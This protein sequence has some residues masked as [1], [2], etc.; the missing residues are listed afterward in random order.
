MDITDTGTDDII[1]GIPWLKEHNPT[2]NWVTGKLQFTRCKHRKQPPGNGIPSEDEEHDLFVMREGTPDLRLENNNMEWLM[3]TKEGKDPIPREYE[4]YKNLFKEDLPEEALPKHQPWDH[5]IPLIEGSK[6]A[7]KKIYPMNETQL[8]ALKEYL[9]ENLKKG[10]IR[11][12]Q[13]PAGYPLF[14]VPKKGGK[15]RPVI[16]YRQLNEIT[17]KNRYPLPL[18]GE[19]MDRLRGANWFTT[20]D[21]KGAYNLIR[22]KEG[23]EW[24]T[25]FRT[26]YGLYEYLVMPFG[27]TNAPASFQSFINNVLRG[28][29]DDFVVVYLDDILIYSENLEQHRKHVHK[30]L[31]QL[32]KADLRIEPEKS[33]FHKQEVDFLG[34]VISPNQIKMDPRKI[35]AI[36]EWPRPQNVKDIQS[37]LGFGNFY[38]RFIQGYSKIVNPLTKLTRKGV[39]F[40]WGTEQQRAFD[41]L[42]ERF[43]KAPVLTT[44][45]PNKQITLETDASDYAIGACLSQPDQNNKLHPVAYYSRTMSPAE[46]NYDIHDKELLAIVVA[47]E[48]WKVYLEGPQYPVQV[49]TDHK[50]LTFFTST[51]VLNRR[52][53]RWAEELA[54]FNY[55]ISYQKGSENNR[56]DA[57][58][59][60]SDYIANKKPISHAIFT[61]QDNGDI[62]HNTQRLAATLQEQDVYWKNEILE[63][64][65]T[66]PFAQT[67]Q[68]TGPAGFVLENNG[69]WT[70]E[71]RIYVPTK[72]HEKVI[73]EIHDQDH[74]GIG[75]TMERIMRH[76]YVPQLRKKV[77][78]HIL[79]CHKCQTNKNERHKPYGMLQPI[80][81]PKGAWECLT[82][83][84]ITDLPKSKG[85][86]ANTIHDTIVVIVDKLT[87]YA[88]FLPFEKTGTA[89]QLA[90]LMVDRIFA[91]H[92]MPSKLITD[93][94]KLFL[95]QFWQTSMEMMGVKHK[96]STAYHPQTDGQTERVNQT[97]EQYLRMFL[98]HQQDNWA[99]ILPVAQ[100]TYNSYSNTSTATAPFT[101]VFGYIPTL[102]FQEKALTTFAIQADQEITFLKKSHDQ[103]KMDITK[104]SAT[105][106]HHANK[107]RS[108][109]PDLKEGDTVYLRRKN[110]KTKRPSRKLDQTKLGPFKI[111]K[112]Q[113]P[114]TYRLKLPKTMRIHPV[115]HVSLLEPTPNPVQYQDPIELHPETEEPMWEVERIL[116]H[117]ETRQGTKYLVKWKGF[118]PEENTWE[119]IIHFGNSE[120]IQDYHRQ[121]NQPR[122]SQDLRPPPREES[123]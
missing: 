107:Q 38:R 98:N 32:D 90:Y 85:Y 112:K 3:T 26:K 22:M 10:F 80:P 116:D 118:G 14:F 104:A 12:S 79:S 83:D 72:L 74:Q 89:K 59:R 56:A 123:Q 45:D 70:V 96:K 65:K 15:L 48:Q 53:V 103:L 75:R 20:M 41:E 31:E 40:T 67:L 97:L 109:G 113:G 4:R 115:F 37:F 21:I 27:L 29:L 86:N 91:T 68:K 78:K 23:E 55:K 54:K 111:L 7:F 63:C 73:Q 119:P 1:L 66:D 18:I 28:Y 2:V 81:A 84:F 51:K 52:Q 46:M 13:S 60:R 99:T 102:R 110:I 33:H 92:G 94:D 16:D 43:T 88:Y 57:L 122:R 25:A 64:Y 19:M 76:Y 120:P 6:P 34:F 49:L 58:S 24:K 11:E 9:D 30:V 8:K 17:V 106:A 5:E 62:V 114:V 77:E 69:L 47:F 82:M 35:K 95:S 108:C 121:N 87:K 117:R 42:R 105:Q 61:T 100:F 36:L 101:A 93:R 50:N 71:N 39:P 44:F